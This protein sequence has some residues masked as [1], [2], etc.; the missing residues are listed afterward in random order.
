MDDNVGKEIRFK[1]TNHEG[2]S[3]W[4]DSI[5]DCCISVRTSDHLERRYKVPIA[6]RWNYLERMVLVTLNNR[7][8]MTYPLLLGRNFLEQDFV[9]DAAVDSDM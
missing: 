3:H 8:S 5:I 4:I 6:L 7:A 2:A 9:V 1:V